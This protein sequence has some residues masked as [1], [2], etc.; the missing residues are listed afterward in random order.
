MGTQLGFGFGKGRRVIKTI[1]RDDALTRALER[2]RTWA[3]QHG[4]ED[5][6]PITVA[7]AGDGACTEPLPKYFRGARQQARRLRMAKAR[8]RSERR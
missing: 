4:V 3:R 1:I 7:C 6:A 8:L 2:Q 5:A